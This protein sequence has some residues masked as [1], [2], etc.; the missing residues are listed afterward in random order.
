M[1][2]DLTGLQR[3]FDAVLL[4][5]AIVHSLSH[6]TYSFHTLARTF[7]HQKFQPRHVRK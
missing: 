1:L 5:H 4:M 7:D 2:K 6:A 3:Q